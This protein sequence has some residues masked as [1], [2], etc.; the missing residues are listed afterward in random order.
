MKK[1]KLLSKYA[2]RRSAL[3]NLIFKNMVLIYRL[4]KFTINHFKQ[5]W[6]F[7]GLLNSVLYVKIRSKI[8]IRKNIKL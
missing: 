4:I 1:K 6:Y 5:D 8:S 3:C 2:N 7:I